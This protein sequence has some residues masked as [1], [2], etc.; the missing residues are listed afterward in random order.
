[1]QGI[2]QLQLLWQQESCAVAKMTAQCAPYM[3]AIAAGPG[4]ILV[5]DSG[6]SPA[7]TV[8]DGPV[9]RL[10]GRVL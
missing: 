1:M 6:Q 5:I 2:L 9:I 8:L 7:G 3:G 4:R 10:P